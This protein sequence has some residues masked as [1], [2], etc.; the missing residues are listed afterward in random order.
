MDG[1]T[2]EKNNLQ[3]M[4]K[5]FSNNIANKIIY[6]NNNNNKV[7]LLSSTLSSIYKQQQLRQLVTGAFLSILFLQDTF[8][9]ASEK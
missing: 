4:K 9:I 3:W 1:D 7:L 5:I 2:S 8:K 6:Y